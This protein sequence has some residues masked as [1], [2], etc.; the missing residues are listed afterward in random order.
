[1]RFK[2]NK[3]VHAI[4]LCIEGAYKAYPGS[5]SRWRS[6]R[7]RFLFRSLIW[8]KTTVPWLFV[9]LRSRHADIAAQCPWI[10]E[11][12]HRPFLHRSLSA[13]Q[14]LTVSVEHA[15]LSYKLAPRIVDELERDGLCPLAIIS[16]SER[17]WYVQV[18]MLSRFEKEGDWTLTIRDSQGYRL[19]SCTF[20]IATIGRRRQRPRL[21]IG[22]VQGPDRSVDGRDLY[23]TL[24]KQ[25][26]G[27]RP[28]S[29]VIYLAQSLAN[30]LGLRSAL[31]VD[32]DTHVYA[33]WRYRCAKHRIA[34]DYRGLCPAL[35]NTPSWQ[36]WLV[37]GIPQARRARADA[38][39]E[40]QPGTVRANRQQLRSSLDVQIRSS[41]HGRVPRQ[42]M[43][44]G[45]SNGLF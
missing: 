20:S 32:N 3:L 4:A 42:S 7:L 24:T 18:E 29:L 13:R 10:L 6:R 35:G 33:S 5:G 30:V 17:R 31:M 25:W 8:W 19:V 22:C 26:H 41:V 28:K 40:A 45:D 12:I 38:G 9:C 16:S 11:R 44:T 14:R 36:G 1:M 23:R 15:Y 34:A 39:H 43:A 21:L 27:W 37:L 2:N